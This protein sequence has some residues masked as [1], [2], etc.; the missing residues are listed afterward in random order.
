MI[1]NNFKKAVVLRKMK[2]NSSEIIISKQ[3]YQ[4][5]NHKK[6]LNAIIQKTSRRVPLYPYI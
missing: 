3:L 5:L 1:N 2:L 6:R 4:Q